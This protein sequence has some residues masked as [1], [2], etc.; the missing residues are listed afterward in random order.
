MEDS[1][2]FDF[3][4][5]QRLFEHRVRDLGESRGGVLQ[6]RMLDGARKR[7][8]LSG[9]TLLSHERLD[10][11]VNHVAQRHETHEAPE[12]PKC[13]HRVVNKLVDE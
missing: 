3:G 12:Q 11:Q 1:G 4:L 9:P 8:R 2:A 5:D 13:L 7:L 6:V 10:D